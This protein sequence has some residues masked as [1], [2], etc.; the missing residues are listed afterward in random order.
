MVHVA[1]RALQFGAMTSTSAS[2]CVLRLENSVFFIVVSG[3]TFCGLHIFLYFIQFIH[4][5]TDASSF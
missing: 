1:Q 5:S 4:L 3:Y 2:E